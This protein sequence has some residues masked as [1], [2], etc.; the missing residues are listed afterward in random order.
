MPAKILSVVGDR[1]LGATRRELLASAGYNATTTTSFSEALTLLMSSGWD[2]II[3]GHATPQA[4]RAVLIKEARGR[5]VPVLLLHLGEVGLSRD[6]DF[7]FDLGD[8]P[9]AFMNCVANALRQGEK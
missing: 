3:V 1:T 2:L 6:G 4:E 5:G 8:G 7:H 9:E